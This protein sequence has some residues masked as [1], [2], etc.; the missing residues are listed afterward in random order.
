MVED[1]R[2]RLGTTYNYVL[3]NW[4]TG[5]RTVSDAPPTVI[6]AIEKSLTSQAVSSHR[7]AIRSSYDEDSGLCILSVQS[8]YPIDSAKQTEPGSPSFVHAIAT[9]ELQLDDLSTDNLERLFESLYGCPLLL[10]IK[11]RQG[12]FSQSEFPQDRESALAIFLLRKHLAKCFPTQAPSSALPLSSLLT[13]TRSTSDSDS[14]DTI[15]DTFTLRKEVLGTEEKYVSPLAEG[16]KSTPD[17]ASQPSPTEP[18]QEGSVSQ[19]R[20]DPSR[21][22]FGLFQ[23]TAAASL[24][25]LL[26]ASLLLTGLF[27]FSDQLSALFDRTASTVNQRDTV[28]QDPQFEAIRQ[29]T[30]LLEDVI[31][32]YESELKE[33]RK[34]V[35]QASREVASISATEALIAKPTVVVPVIQKA[36]IMPEAS[37]PQRVEEPNPPGMFEIQI[38]NSSFL[39]PIPSQEDNEP[40]RI[41]QDRERY[42]VTGMISQSDGTW[43]EI[44]R[45]WIKKNS[46]IIEVETMESTAEGTATPSPLQADYPGL[47]E[48]QIARG[49]NLYSIP[50]IE[51]IEDVQLLKDREVHTVISEYAGEDGLWYALRYGWVKKTSRISIV[52]G[53]ANQPAPDSTPVRTP[54]F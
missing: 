44:R 23:L 46:R 13:L 5:F 51:R 17:I 9:N 16:S 54:D 2:S 21:R 4:K 8:P 38:R 39:R 41:L 24:G 3:A 53:P 15:M 45:G 50:N 1:E 26:G 25:S 6:A 28:S 33:L 10:G 43:Y 29:Q 34:E 7:E 11:L 48:V 12:E 52:K 47:F 40:T 35:R 32:G 49:V 22:T 30:A 36:V 37:Q 42:T 19:P 20:P 27:L 18:A 14:D 31:Q